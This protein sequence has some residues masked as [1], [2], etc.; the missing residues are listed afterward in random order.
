M[1]YNYIIITLWNQT[2]QRSLIL[3]FNNMQYV[4]PKRKL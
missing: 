4:M 2:P 3:N 1:I